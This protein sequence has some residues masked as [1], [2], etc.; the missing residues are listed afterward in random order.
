MVKNSS[1]STFFRESKNTTPLVRDNIATKYMTVTKISQALFY[2]IE[3]FL[4]LSMLEVINKNNFENSN[5]FRNFDLK[6]VVLF[7]QFLKKFNVF[8]D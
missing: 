8:L 3:R 5:F 2:A 4:T 1:F 6:Y 7:D